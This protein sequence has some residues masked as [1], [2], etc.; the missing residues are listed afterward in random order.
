M[1][2]VDAYDAITSARPY[3]VAF[4]HAEAVR[5][6]AVDRDRHFDPVLVDAFL[7]CHD[8]FARVRA[9]LRSASS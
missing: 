5:R 2:L 6:I 7:S 3:K 4:D 8:R 1:A 9:D